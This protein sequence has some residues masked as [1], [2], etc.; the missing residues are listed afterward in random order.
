[1]LVWNP[2]W[3]DAGELGSHRGFVSNPRALPSTATLEFASVASFTYKPKN[4]PNKGKT[5]PRLA[6]IL[7]PNF[8]GY[9]HA[10]TLKNIDRDVMVETIFPIVKGGMDDPYE[11]YHSIYKPSFMYGLNAYRTYI[12]ERISGI[13]MFSYDVSE[14]TPVEDEKRSEPEQMAEYDRQ[15]DK[16]SK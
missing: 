5:Q 12:I 9:C 7:H 11:F 10:I 6:F 4:E 16:E 3:G 13:T 14:E 15:I 1:M 2:A 8:Q